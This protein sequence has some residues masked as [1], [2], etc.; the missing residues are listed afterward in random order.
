MAASQAL[1]FY[2][3]ENI[4]SRGLRTNQ[5]LQGVVNEIY[6]PLFL[7]YL[8]ATLLRSI[9]ANSRVGFASFLQRWLGIPHNVLIHLSWVDHT[10]V[11][12]GVK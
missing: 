1:C 8:W 5:G 11:S 12:I 4:L 7:D 9:R 2:C 10:P 3:F 6:Q